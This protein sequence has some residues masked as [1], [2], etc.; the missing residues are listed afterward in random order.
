MLIRMA[1]PTRKPP[2]K[3]VGVYL[4]PDLIRDI[5]AFLDE[6]GISR[7]DFFEAAA[8]RE[9]NDPSLPS[10]PHSEQLPLGA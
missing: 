1:R 7:R 2:S 6:R 3:L 9:M 5:A 8:R 10:A 4:S